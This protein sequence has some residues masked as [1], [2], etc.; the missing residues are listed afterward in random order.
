MEIQ[1]IPVEN[2]PIPE[3]GVFLVYLKEKFV[4][5]RTHVARRV[6]TPNSDFYTIGNYFSYDCPKV[7]HW[8]LIGDNFPDGEA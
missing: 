2:K 8:A 6:R 7:T 5:L 4:G 1:W 3:E